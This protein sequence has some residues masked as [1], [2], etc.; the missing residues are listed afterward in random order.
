MA[1]TSRLNKTLKEQKFF[2][3]NEAIALS[4]KRRKDLDCRDNFPIFKIFVEFE[5]YET[6][7]DA[8]QTS[9][10]HIESYL[11]S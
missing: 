7:A 6:A 2:C 1:V 10:I 8:R 9:Y 3:L 5:K 11:A 4:E